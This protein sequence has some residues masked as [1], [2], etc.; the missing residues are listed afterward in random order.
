MIGR[1][2]ERFLKDSGM[3]PTQFGTIVARDPRLVFDLRKGREP[4]PRMCARIAA[5]M[6]SGR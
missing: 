5:F 1:K 3:S 6:E 2:V 4:G